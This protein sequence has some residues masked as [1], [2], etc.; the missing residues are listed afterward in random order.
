M[1]CGWLV[2]DCLTCIP[3]TKTLWHD[4]LD[5]I[6]GL[7][8][9]TG[10]FT[11][12]GKLES[13]IESEY[14]HSKPDYIIRN[15]TYFRK[16]NVPVK[17][18]SLLQ[19]IVDGPLRQRQIDVCNNSSVVIFNSPYTYNT[20]KDVVNPPQS[21]IIPLGVDFNMFKP[22]EKN[23]LIDKYGILPN[24]ILFV[25]SVGA[26]KGFDI[27]MDCVNNG[28]YNYCFVMKDDFNVSH[29][30]IRVFNRIP[31]S[32]LI[33]IYN[34]CAMLVCTS[35]TETQHL[36]GIEAAACG[37]PIVASNVGAYYNR[38]GGEWGR[39]VLDGNFLK[40]IS[41]VMDN[42]D[43]FHPREYFLDAGYSKEVCMV[44]WKNIVENL[45]D[46]N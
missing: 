29:P 11:G 5:V 25:G 39:L 46:L 9:K 2:N 38:N 3:G 36:A 41:Y 17:T 1:K 19:D 34:A 35:R 27:M 4:L 42:L 26:V 31:H 10:G 12:A 40:E 6:P 13:K 37:L 21:E 16:I 28:H 15:A 30:R 7:I 20:Y 45:W 23:G 14:A 8:D 24:S 43:K 44:R 32:S 18:I 22:I 33:E